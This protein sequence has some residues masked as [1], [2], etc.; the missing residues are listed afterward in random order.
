MMSKLDENYWR[1]WAVY[2]PMSDEDWQK[3][4]RVQAECLPNAIEEHERAERSAQ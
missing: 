4:L 2:K 3:T 1:K